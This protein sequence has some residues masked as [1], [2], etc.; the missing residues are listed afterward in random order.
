MDT[1][2]LILGGATLYKYLFIIN[3]SVQIKTLAGSFSK[4]KALVGAFSKNLKIT[5]KYRG[6]LSAVGGQGSQL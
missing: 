1:C 4:E 2:A 3:N 6:H 5:A